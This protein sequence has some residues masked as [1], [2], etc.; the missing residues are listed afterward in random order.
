MLRDTYVDNRGEMKYN[1]DITCQYARCIDIEKGVSRVKLYTPDYNSRF[2]C[3]ADKCR[4]SCCIGWEIDIDNETYSRYKAVGGELG[5]RLADGICEE[6][7]TAHFVLDADERCPFLNRSGLCDI[8]TELGED[9]LCSICADHP[10]WRGFYSDRVEMG[11]GLCCE[12]AAELIVTNSGKTKLVLVSDDNGG[13]DTDAADTSMFELRERLVDIL[14][15]RSE[16]ISTRFEKMPSEVGGSF[17]TKSISQ[18]AD[19][20]LSLERL[21]DEWTSRLERLRSADDEE[22]AKVC[23]RVSETAAEQLAVY[24]IYRHFGDAVYDGRFFGRAAFAILSTYIIAAVCTVCGAELVDAAR[25]YSAEIE[26]CE[27]NMEKLFDLLEG[28]GEKYR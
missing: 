9:A 23:G 4:H 22:I 7:G 26:Y 18:W 27:E 15:N 6:N 21:D 1:I 20:Y 13:E 8:I 19:I 5:K 16:P 24:F 14:Q 12:A 11:V 10:R 2:S 3:I 25:M 17:P 28:D